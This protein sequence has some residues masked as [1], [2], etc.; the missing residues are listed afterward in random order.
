M[1][2]REALEANIGHR[3]TA[4]DT[5]TLKLILV[6]MKAGRVARAFELAS[7]LNKMKSI[8]GALRLATEHR[9]ANKNYCSN[10]TKHY[11]LCRQQRISQDFHIILLAAELWLIP[12][13]VESYGLSN[14]IPTN[15]IEWKRTMDDCL[16]CQQTNGTDLSAVGLNAYPALLPEFLSACLPPDIP[17]HKCPLQADG[18]GRADIGADP[19]PY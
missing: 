16:W 5:S 1:E 12:R 4:V 6:A 14:E 15:L 9:S 11:H 3:E 2:E 18:P 10:T 13:G 17:A 8:K 19:A 7:Q